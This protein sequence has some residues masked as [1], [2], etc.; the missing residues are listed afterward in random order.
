VSAVA[1]LACELIALSSPSGGEGAA[2]ARCADALRDL[3][4]RVSLDD[5]G[6]VLGE[7]G[8]R[9][10]RLLFDGHIDTVAANAGWTR[11]ALAPSVEDG[12]LYGLGSVDMKGPIAAMMLGV[13]DAIAAG[14]LAGTVGVSISTLEEVVEGAALAA[15][16][17]RFRPDAVVIAE[18]SDLKLM[19]AQRGRAELLVEIEGKAAH[20][21][22]PERGVNALEAAAAFVSAL[23]Q[24]PVPHDEYLGD[25]ILVPTEAVT[26]P[27]PGISVVPSRARVR[28][29]RRTLPGETAEQVLAELEP[30]LAEARR[31][32]ALAS[33]RLT[34]GDVRTYTGIALTEERFLPAWSLDPEAPL[35]RG[36]R[37][38][39][40]EALGRVELSHYGFCTNGSLT[41]GRLGIPTI[42]F[43]PGDTEQAHRADEHVAVA[44]LEAGRRG[45][46]ALAAIDL[47]D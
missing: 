43:G 37:H 15:V 33:A 35:A 13:A 30:A 38:A 47:E 22:F 25:G 12:V 21:A 26:D 36:A 31:E 18:P 14:R 24:R 5:Q 4:F 29:D 9:G 1:D 10:P 3:G 45:F 11:D 34:T 6:N 16:V 23:A 46:A 42:G 27:L 44:D 39:L 17:E 40:T 20:A 32:G 7:A 8:D 19:L 41:A 2:A 28:L